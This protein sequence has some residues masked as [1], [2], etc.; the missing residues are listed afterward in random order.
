M[1][2]R[3]LSIALCLL[4]AGIMAFLAAGCSVV[5]GNG[6][7]ETRDVRIERALT[8]VVNS[9]SFDIVVDPSLT[10]KAVLV[11]ESNIL[12]LLDVGQSAG[13]VFTV[14]FKR[15]V[16]PAPQQTVEVRVPKMQGG[17]YEI[18]G[19]GNVT[20]EGS[21]PLTGDAFELRVN[22]S[23]N[24]DLNLECARLKIGIA[25]MGN[26]D[27]K[28]KADALEVS[29]TGSGNINASDCKAVR[30]DIRIVGSG[31]AFVQVTDTLKTSIIGAGNVVYKGEP[32]NVTMD[33]AGSGKVQKQE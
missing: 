30:A 7:V 26:V 2:R 4:M 31:D 19:S 16:I 23:G 27:L 15:G 18:N 9:G 8:G 33:G 6:R 3:A 20:Q 14:A 21:G 13:G 12:D 17:L 28:G 1:R 29:V 11:G 5:G 25:G 10:G 24:V 32:K 22:G